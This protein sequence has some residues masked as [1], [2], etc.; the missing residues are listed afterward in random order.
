MPRAIRGS[1][2]RYYSKNR[3]LIAVNEIRRGGEV[4]GAADGSADSS[5]GQDRHCTLLA[6]RVPA[7]DPPGRSVGEDRLGDRM[8]LCW[9]V[10]KEKPKCASSPAFISRN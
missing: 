7:C 9:A 1:R 2:I 4:V 6:Q 3:W 8:M 5:F 10:T